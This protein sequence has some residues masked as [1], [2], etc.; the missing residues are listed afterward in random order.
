MGGAVASRA[1]SAFCQCL[2]KT[3]EIC[4]ALAKPPATH[5][6][7][8]ANV[9]QKC[10]TFAKHWQIPLPHAVFVFLAPATPAA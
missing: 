6:N 9:W 10:L 7:D 8:F 1:L 2:A 4:Q 5:A 3:S